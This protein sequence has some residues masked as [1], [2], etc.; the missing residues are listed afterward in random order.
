MRIAASVRVEIL[1]TNQELDEPTS[2]FHGV[3]QSPSLSGRK[4]QVTCNEWGEAMDQKVPNFFIQRVCN[5]RVYDVGTCRAS[6]A[7]F[8]ISVT[9]LGAA[10]RTIVA[11]GAGLVGKPQ[12][13][14]AQGWI[15]IGTGLDRRVVFIMSSTAAF[16]DEVELS[17][18]SILDLE[19]PMS[20]ILV[21]GCDGLRSTCISKFNN[22]LNFGGHATP[23]DNLTLIAIKVDATT[24][25]KK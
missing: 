2:L 15:D 6:K 24:G 13:W 4:I 7:A 19:L 17:V 14:F 18:S 23:K 3:V 1:E 5:Y 21:P 22:L 16:D 12:D 25:G 11:Q 20:A 9:L 10:G 8:Q